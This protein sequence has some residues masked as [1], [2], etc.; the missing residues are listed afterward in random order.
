[1]HVESLPPLQLAS[2]GIFSSYLR[3]ARE[4][5]KHANIF[6]KFPIA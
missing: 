2:Q 4:K 1:M 3:E 5:V 6:F